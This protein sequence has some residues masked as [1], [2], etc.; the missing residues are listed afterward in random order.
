MRPMDVQ[1]SNS[2]DV[3]YG[4]SGQLGFKATD[5]SSPS[6]L[7][8]T[9]AT[10]VANLDPP[11]TASPPFWSPTASASTSASIQTT[12]T[13]LASTVNYNGLIGY[14]ATD[15]LAFTSESC[16][17]SCSFDLPVTVQVS[18]ILA[19]L[20]DSINDD[21]MSNNMVLL[22]TQIIMSIFYGTLALTAIASN[23]I[24]CY[25]VLS[26]QRMRTATNYFIVNLAVGD[27]L[28]ALLCIPFTF[29]ANLIFQYWPFG[30]SL[31]VIVSYSQANSVFIR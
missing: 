30:L 18:L 3:A 11:H 5:S 2:L 23:M 24:V 31:C 29:P 14:N 27:I 20:W 4:A 28:M 22:K 13:G 7:L 17:G 16:N 1:V 9:P 8:I 26:N 25:I 19:P 10:R 6:N 12:M 21:Y 15:P